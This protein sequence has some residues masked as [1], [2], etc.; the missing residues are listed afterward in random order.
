MKPESRNCSAAELV[1]M[2]VSKTFITIL[3][4]VTV[5][6][7]QQKTHCAGLQVPGGQHSISSMSQ[8]MSSSAIQ[9]SVSP[10]IISDVCVLIR[11]TGAITIDRKEIKSM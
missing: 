3:S 11:A 7:K 2:P 8:V 9:H 1:L 4:W 5:Q 6:A 10:Q